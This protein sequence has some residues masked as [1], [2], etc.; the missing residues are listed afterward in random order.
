M[1]T[2]TFGRF[3][4]RYHNREEWVNYDDDAVEIDGQFIKAETLFEKVAEGKIKKMIAPES[5]ETKR[6]I[7][8]TFK[9]IKKGSYA[10]HN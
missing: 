2:H 5:L 8:R 9:Q 7:E 6:I 3:E 10:D 1:V 4:S